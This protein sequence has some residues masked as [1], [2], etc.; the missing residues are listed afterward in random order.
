MKELLRLGLILAVAMVGSALGQSYP[1]WS[2]GFVPG[3]GRTG[4]AAQGSGAGTWDDWW[5]FKADKANGVLTSPTITGGTI[6]GTALGSTTPVSAVIAGVTTN[7]SAATGVVGE[8]LTASATTP[9]SVSTLTNI[10][11]I[12]LSPGDWE[13]F[14]NVYFVMTGNQGANFQSW[15]N[16]VSVTQP[17]GAPYTPT[18]T[19]FAG[20]ASTISNITQ[21][22]VPVRDQREHHDHGVSVGRFL[23]L[24]QRRDLPGERLYQRAPDAIGATFVS[25]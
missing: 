22:P 19:V 11:S 23:Q 13:I 15:F 4:G 14:G 7:S 20:T 8:T 17:T 6:D 12:S 25:N 3:A 1:Q 5:G 24:G 21:A 10:T 16:N 2:S 9:I 18:L